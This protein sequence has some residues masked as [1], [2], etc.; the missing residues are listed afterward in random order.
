MM[1]VVIDESATLLFNV[2]AHVLSGSLM[3]SLEGLS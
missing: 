3:V 1:S 2:R